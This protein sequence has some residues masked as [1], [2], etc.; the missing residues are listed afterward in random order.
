VTNPGNGVGVGDD[1]ED[2]HRG[3]ASGSAGD[4]DGE[5]ASQ[6]RRPGH[7]TRAGGRLGLAR[8]GPPAV[9]VDAGPAHLEDIE[10]HE[11]ERRRPDMPYGAPS[12]R[13]RLV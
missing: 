10:Q 11:F 6:E 1:L 8:A 3:G 7:S 5:D 2:A 13:V 4:V 9:A 12:A